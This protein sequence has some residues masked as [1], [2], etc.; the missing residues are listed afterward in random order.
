[1]IKYALLAAVMACSFAAA[2]RADLTTPPIPECRLTLDGL[3][4]AVVDNPGTT[5]IILTEEQSVDFVKIYNVKNP[6]A[7]VYPPA[8]KIVAFTQWTPKDSRGLLIFFNADGC[9]TYKGSFFTKTINDFLALHSG[10]QGLLGKEIDFYFKT[11][12][13]PGFIKAE[14]E[15]GFIKV[16]EWGVAPS[17]IISDGGSVFTTS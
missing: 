3:A 5:S 4:Q 12:T 9:L 2:A 17:R 10:I 1:M 16:E 13:D 7:A 6:G 11:E 14:A 8:V 15:Y